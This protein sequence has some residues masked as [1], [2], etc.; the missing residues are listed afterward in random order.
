MYEAGPLRCKYVVEHN[1]ELMDKICEMVK[2]DQVA[3]WVGANPILRSQLKFVYDTL[4]IMFD[5][6]LRFMMIDSTQNKQIIE[7]VVPKYLAFHAL[8]NKVKIDCGRE[9]KT[10]KKTEKN[11]RRKMQGL[12]PMDSVSE[13]KFEDPTPVKEVKKPEVKKMKKGKAVVIEEEVPRP[14]DENDKDINNY[15]RYWTFVNYFNEEDEMV[16]T[17]REGSFALGRVNPAVV[18]DM[19]DH[20]LLQGFGLLSRMG[21]REDK[22]KVIKHN[23]E[24]FLKIQREREKMTAVKNKE[25]YDPIAE[26]IA[27]DKKREFTRAFRPDQHVWNFEEEENP[28]PHVLREDANPTAAYVDGRIEEVLAIIDHLAHELKTH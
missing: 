27:Q 10:N 5:S 18:T 2:V 17:W 21:K 15:G 8:R 9:S 19:D 7:E 28:T 1:T 6:P 14:T 24:T 4:K 25:E 12:D 13:F 26:G 3:Q 11:D 20:F 22:Q 23:I 16:N